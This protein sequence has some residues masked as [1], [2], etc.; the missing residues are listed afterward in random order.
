LIIWVALTALFVPKQVHGVNLALPWRLK[1]RV[2]TSLAAFTRFGRTIRA[3]DSR[4]NS[5][6]S[7][8]RAPNSRIFNEKSD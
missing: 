4:R 7:A 5:I 3:I 1:F 8:R 2:M 6:A